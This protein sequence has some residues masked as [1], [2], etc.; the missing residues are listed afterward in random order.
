[1]PTT[2][3]FPRK[4]ALSL[5][6][7]FGPSGYVLQKGTLTWRQC[8]AARQRRLWR[9]C[10]RLGAREPVSILLGE[11]KSRDFDLAKAAC[12]TLTWPLCRFRSQRD[13]YIYISKVSREQRVSA[14]SLPIWE[15][16]DQ[17]LVTRV[18]RAPRAADAVL[19][20]GRAPGL[21]DARHVSELLLTAHEDLYGASLAPLFFPAKRE[22]SRGACAV[23]RVAQERSGEGARGAGRACARHSLCVVERS[24]VGRAL[25]QP[26]ADRRRDRAQQELVRVQQHHHPVR[27]VLSLVRISRLKGGAGSG[28]DSKSL[29]FA[30]V[31]ATRR[32]TKGTHTRGPLCFYPK[33]LSS[34]ARDLL[35]FFLPR[36]KKKVVFFFAV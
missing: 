28:Q 23:S 27:V 31:R 10:E 18:G 17:S 33:P 8:F 4:K 2:A 19:L 30:N 32:S 35:C 9:W 22:S 13:S 16:T 3:F 36:D 7:S 20:R 34:L 21:D 12:L 5:S 6:L 14:V 1:M 25:R 24:L 11:K 29:R 15:T 26:R